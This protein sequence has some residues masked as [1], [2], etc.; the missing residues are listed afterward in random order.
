MSAGGRLF[1]V[2]VPDWGQDHLTV[3]A[4]VAYVDGELAERP[5]DRATRHLCHVSGVRCAG[6]RAGPGPVG[7]AVGALSEPAVLAD[8]GAAGDPAGHRAPRPA[9]GLAIPDGRS[10][11]A[12]ARSP[13]PHAWRSPRAVRRHDA[14]GRSPPRLPGWRSA[15]APRPARV[16]LRRPGRVRRSPV[17][18]SA[19]SPSAPSVIAADTPSPSGSAVPPLPSTPICSS[20]ASRLIVLRLR[21]SPV[22]QA[23]CGARSAQEP[24]RVCRRMTEHTA[25]PRRQGATRRSRAPGPSRRGSARA[26]WSGL[27]VDP[28]VA[29]AFGRPARRRRRASRRPRPAR[30]TARARP[31]CAAA[32]PR[33]AL[34]RRVRP[35]GRRRRPALQRPPGPAARPPTTPTTPFWADGAAADPWRN[36]ESPVGSGPPGDTDSGRT[37][38]RPRRRAPGSACARCCSAVASTRERW[39]C[40]PWS[41]C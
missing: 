27:H 15:P 37:R 14:P 35:A 22:L 17:S 20:P 39:P 25:G 38:P 4:V 6:R 29:A 40:S 7:A 33:A 31:A 9:A 8:V 10:C 1:S 3:E 24:G 23:R 16:P 36:P 5:Y 18:R 30:T 12:G 34:G 13:H 2:Q 21:T 32:R 41:R 11:R 28:E 26:R 19:R